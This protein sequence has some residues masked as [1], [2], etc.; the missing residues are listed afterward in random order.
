MDN[1]MYVVCLHLDPN[2]ALFIYGIMVL[3]RYYIFIL[4][5]IKFL[6]FNLKSLG[7]LRSPS[8]KEFE[9]RNVCY[10]CAVICTGTE[11]ESGIENASDKELMSVFGRNLHDTVVTNSILEIK[12][13]LYCPSC[14]TQQS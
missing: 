3:L 13:A 8:T 2:N 10:L 4:I 12:L 11:V 6:P 14:V 5:C 7:S 9:M 1:I